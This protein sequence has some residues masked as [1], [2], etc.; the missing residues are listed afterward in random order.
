MMDGYL[1]A[2]P[3]TTTEVTISNLP[4]VAGGYML[5]IYGD[6]T[7]DPSN[8]TTQSYYIA[9]PDNGDGPVYAEL[10]DPPGQTFD[11][12]FVYANQAPGNYT[13]MV[14]GGTGFTL[15]VNSP[16]ANPEHAIINGIQIVRADRIFYGGFD[17]AP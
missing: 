8:L 17:N 1:D 9:T 14:V 12:N 2:N 13:T 5:Y 4:S 3:N 15:T 10:L 11:G 7:D 6:G 16:P